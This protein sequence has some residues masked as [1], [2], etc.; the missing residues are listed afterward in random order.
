MENNTWVEKE[1]LVKMGYLKLVQR[2]ELESRHH[3]TDMLGSGGGKF[4]PTGSQSARVPLMQLNSQPLGSEILC[5]VVWSLA[6]HRMCIKTPIFNDSVLDQLK[7]LGGACQLLF[8]FSQN[9]FFTDGISGSLKLTPCASTTGI[10]GSLKLAP[11]VSTNGI[12][13][14][15]KPARAITVEPPMQSAVVISPRSSALSVLRILTELK[16]QTCI[17]VTRSHLA[18]TFSML[19]I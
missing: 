14:S 2:E 6:A 8:V 11:C 5:H 3:C 18:R 13:G 12:S 15:L 10:S 16:S 9:Q 7:S 4:W 17:G 1:I 19:G